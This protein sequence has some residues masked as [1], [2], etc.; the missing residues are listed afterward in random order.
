MRHF[1][2]LQYFAG[3]KLSGLLGQLKILR[4]P[5]AAHITL[6]GPMGQLNMIG[7]PKAANIQVYYLRFEKPYT[8]APR[9]RGYSK[10]YI[11]YI[12]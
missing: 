6:A 10:I 8:T 12:E 5:L 9:L 3:P 1:L 11:N 2:V 7:R 4:R